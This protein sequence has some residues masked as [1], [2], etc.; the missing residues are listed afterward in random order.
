MLR[1][2]P[3]EH[4]RWSRITSSNL[5]RFLFLLAEKEEA[6]FSLEFTFI[7]NGFYTVKQTRNAIEALT[8]GGNPSKV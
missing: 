2:S 7:V 4:L 1:E 6:I 3:A 8:T 5:Y